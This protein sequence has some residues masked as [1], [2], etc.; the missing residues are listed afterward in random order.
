MLK[1][2]ICF[3]YFIYRNLVW[4]WDSIE[5]QTTLIFRLSSRLVSVSIRKNILPLGH[6]ISSSIINVQWHSQSRIYLR[7]F[8]TAPNLVRLMKKSLK[9]NIIWQSIL[10]HPHRERRSCLLILWDKEVGCPYKIRSRYTK[11]HMLRI[12]KT[13]NRPKVS[14]KDK[15][16]WETNTT[17]S[18]LGISGLMP[19]LKLTQRFTHKHKHQS[20]HRLS[21]FHKTRTCSTLIR[22]INFRIS[23]TVRVGITHAYKIMQLG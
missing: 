20:H 5:G 3:N 6:Q 7:Q 16:Q 8:S 19:C 14:I 17:C 18:A 9:M 1:Y 11:S 4:E 12:P 15:S 10:L 21:W 13:L 2:Y 22:R 23:Y